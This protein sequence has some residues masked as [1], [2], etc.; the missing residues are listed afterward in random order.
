MSA[1]RVRWRWITD[2]EDPRTTLL[3]CSVVLVGGSAAVV[4]M[5]D[6][7]GFDAVWAIVWIVVSVGQLVWALL[8]FLTWRE[9]QGTVTSS[10]PHPSGDED[11]R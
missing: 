5:M 1:W 11:L 2:F 7:G 4:A 9:S 8:R 3:V 10:S 6:R